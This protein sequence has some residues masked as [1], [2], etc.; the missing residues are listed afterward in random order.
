MSLTVR[1]L[2]P[3]FLEF[4]DRAAAEDE[5]QQLALW[6]QYVES[7]PEVIQD[8]RR[9]G[10]DPDPQQAFELYPKVLELVRANAEV[11]CSWVEEAAELVMPVLEATH[12]DVHAVV[13]VGLGTANGWVSQF[14]G[15]AT[16]FLAVERIPEGT[17]AQILAAHEFAHAVQLSLPEVA[18][19]DSGPLG[20]WIYAE[21]FATALTAEM[22]PDYGPAEHLWFGDG[23]DD[24]LT[25]CLQVLPA[26][27]AAILADLESEEDDVAARYLTRNSEARFPDRIGYLVGTRLVQ[28]LRRTYGWPELARWS[29]ERATEE[30]RRLLS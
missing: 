25:N 26:A 28:D 27:K 11:A 13:M 2:V 14:R 6:N 24:W 19:T 7:A 29:A 1:N 5:Q 4:W 15:Q 9:S 17:A 12:L 22:L 21:G 20:Q 3:E 10:R 23:Y 8:L 16:L 18:W 30:V